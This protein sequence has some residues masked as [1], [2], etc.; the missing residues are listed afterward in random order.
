MGRKFTHEW[1]KTVLISKQNFVLL[2]HTWLR[3][4]CVQSCLFHEPYIQYSNLRHW[5]LG[6]DGRGKAVFTE[7]HEVKVN[8]PPSNRFVKKVNSATLAFVWNILWSPFCM[9]HIVWLSECLD[10]N[11]FLILNWFLWTKRDLS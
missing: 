4:K 5:S 8:F 3:F 10:G 7:I 2:I 1:T 11:Y 9:V 6:R